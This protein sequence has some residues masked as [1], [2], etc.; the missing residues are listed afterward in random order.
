M[1]EV[2][3]VRI[4]FLKFDG[5]TN[6]A[7]SKDLSGAMGSIFGFAAYLKPSGDTELRLRITLKGSKQ[8]E[9]VVPL[10]E[11]WNRVGL[12]IPYSGEKTG[13]IVLEFSPPVKELSVWGIDAGSVR[14]PEGLE[15][16]NASIADLNAGYISPETLY[17]PQEK[18]LNLDIDREASSSFE[19]SENGMIGLKKCSY[20]GR[21]LPVDSARRGALAFH[22]HAAKRTGH[23]N[24]CRA[25]KKWRI[26]VYFNPK[27]TVDQLH[28]SSVIT[29]ERKFLLREPEILQQIKDRNGK[30]LKSII[31]ERFGRGCFKCGKGLK[32][33]EVELDHTRPL[34]YLWP[35]DMHA[36]CL[37][38]K[39]NNLKKDRFPVD[40]YNESQLKK[41]SK[42][43]GLNYEEL[44][45][46]DVNQ[47]ELDRIVGDLPNFANRVEARTFNAIAR[48]VKEVRHDVDL[49][50]ILGDRDPST[51]L[52]LIKRLGKRPA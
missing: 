41:L 8:Y 44:T 2:P 51:Y 25:C 7:F 38:A 48:K 10:Q 30:G 36:T 21:H 50:K 3:V 9:D 16:A 27:R 42:I 18:A 26:N 52:D 14:F 17:L 4:E 1:K 49:F 19:S 20:C 22:R 34:V 5:S 28:E 29:R 31:W 39:C 33:T 45:K 15:R 35:I 37:C 32:L 6:L 23:Q 13:K 12:A 40:V 46:R 43:T 47:A 24:E 11:N